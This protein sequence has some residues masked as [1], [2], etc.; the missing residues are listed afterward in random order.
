MSLIVCVLG[1]LGSIRGSSLHGACE[2]ILSL[3]VRLQP[4]SD[5]FPDCPSCSLLQLL[6]LLGNVS[7]EIPVRFSRSKVDYIQFINQRC[8]FSCC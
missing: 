4:L 5:Y 2:V 7:F 1:R 3:C 8:L 6:K